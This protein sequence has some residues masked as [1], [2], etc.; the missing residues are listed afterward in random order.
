MT[1]EESVQRHPAM[2]AKALESDLGRFVAREMQWWDADLID[3][4]EDES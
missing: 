1:H 3:D 4:E 2:R